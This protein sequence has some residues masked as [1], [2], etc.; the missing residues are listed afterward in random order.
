[1][2]SGMNS[3]LTR[4]ALIGGAVSC[5][6]ARAWAATPDWDATLVAAAKRQVGVTTVYDPAYVVLPYPGGDI[7]RERGV[8]TDVVVRAYRD[9]F[10]LDLQRLVHEDML[11]EFSAYPARW[12]L[13][14]P[15]ANIDHRRVPNLRTFFLRQGAALPISAD[16]AAHR[17]GDLVT[18]K[19]PGNLDHIMIVSGRSDSGEPLAVHNIGRGA[20]LE[21]VLFLFPHTGRYRF[22][23]PDA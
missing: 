10:D 5:A 6:V 16:P 18:V 2:L 3:G 4:R 23:P 8:C 9:A 22:P 1:M 11:R 7:S 21:P 20:Q 17:D 19:L 14:A 12:G 15:N 13:S